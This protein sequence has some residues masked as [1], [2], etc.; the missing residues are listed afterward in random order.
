MNI[1]VRICSGSAFIQAGR[2][3]ALVLDSILNQYGRILKPGNF[4]SFNLSAP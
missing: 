2:T 3:R 1:T 4:G